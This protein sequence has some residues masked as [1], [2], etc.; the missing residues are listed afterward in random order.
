M[1]L[2]T[3]VSVMQKKI[4]QDYEFTN[5]YIICLTRNGWVNEESY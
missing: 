2:F 3:T 5:V 4:V 1:Q